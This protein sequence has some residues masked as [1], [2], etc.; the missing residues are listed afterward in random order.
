M[1]IHS[2]RLYQSMITFVERADAGMDILQLHISIGSFLA[3][4]KDFRTLSSD[5]S[6]NSIW[7]T[8]RNLVEIHQVWLIC[9]LQAETVLFKIFN[10]VIVLFNQRV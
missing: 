1:L 3:L 7:E 10:S 5:S 8:I 4:N 2:G 9:Q 6:I